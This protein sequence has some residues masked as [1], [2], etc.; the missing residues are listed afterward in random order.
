[1]T[2]A[3]RIRELARTIDD[4]HVIARRIGCDVQYVRVVLHQRSTERYEPAMCKAS[5]KWLAS[6]IEKKRAYMRAYYKRRRRAE[7]QSQATP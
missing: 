2:K 7:V 6:N 5:H 3:G 1:M 4:K